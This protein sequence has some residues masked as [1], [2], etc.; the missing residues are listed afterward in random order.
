MSRF[1]ING[2]VLEAGVSVLLIVA[3]ASCGSDNPA[4][5]VPSGPGSGTLMVV[6]EVAGSESG[7]GVFETEYLATVL[8]SAG[9]A[10]SGASVEFSTPGGTVVLAED[11][12]SAGVYRAASGGYLSGTYSLSVRRG[13]DWASDMGVAAPDVHAITSPQANDTVA[14]GQS[15]A[16]TWSRVIAAQELRLETKDFTSGPEV[17]DGISNVPKP[18]NPARPDQRVRVTRRNWSYPAGVLNGSELEAKLTR[19]VEPIT[20]Q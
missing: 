5:P 17:D 1:N 14:A 13:A 3:T 19:T 12:V 15:I 4:A 20:V 18:K 10:I 16:V 2:R 9:M 11:G 7:A 6:A 8:D